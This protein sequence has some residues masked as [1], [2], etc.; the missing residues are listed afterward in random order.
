[1]IDKKIIIKMYSPFF[2]N[3]SNFKIYNNKNIK[4]PFTKKEIDVIKLHFSS[5]IIYI[6]SY[7]AIVI[8]GVV[9]FK[10]F[11]SVKD[12]KFWI[13]LIDFKQPLDINKPIYF[14]K[15]SGNAII[16]TGE[17]DLEFLLKT[18]STKNFFSIINQEF[19]FQFFC[20][21]FKYQ[22]LISVSSTN[23]TALSYNEYLSFS[24][25]YNKFKIRVRIIHGDITSKKTGI[26]LFKN[27]VVIKPR[28]MYVKIKEEDE[29]LPNKSK[30]YYICFL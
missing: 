20:N 2:N 7:V 22:F 10:I 16:A 28:A 9:G 18:V 23:A 25:W 1:M 5:D 13:Y 15:Y 30:K 24:N 12:D 21:F 26:N 14:N 11:H 6:D 19:P 17:Y 3:T 4:I 8:M 27:N 29:F